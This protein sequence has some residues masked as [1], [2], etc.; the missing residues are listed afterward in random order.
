MLRILVNVHKH[1]LQ[2]I[3][4]HRVLSGSVF[5]VFAVNHHMLKAM[6]V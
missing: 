5:L 2:T 4:R 1:D 6:H 3:R